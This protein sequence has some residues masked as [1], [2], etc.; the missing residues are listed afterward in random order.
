[1]NTKIKEDAPK[2]KFFEQVTDSKD[3]IE[4]KCAADVLNIPNLGR[5][6]L[7]Q[8]LRSIKIL[9]HERITVKLLKKFKK[10]TV[11]II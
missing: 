1:M 9:K 10:K 2:V 5:N 4:M 6:K 11:G 8:F 7:F 3:A